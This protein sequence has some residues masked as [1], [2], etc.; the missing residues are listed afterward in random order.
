MPPPPGN[1]GDSKDCS[2]FSTQAE[3]Q[4]WFDT[5]YPTYGDVANLDGD[6]DGIGYD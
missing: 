4:A 1:P 5:Y 2:D 3:A 6:N